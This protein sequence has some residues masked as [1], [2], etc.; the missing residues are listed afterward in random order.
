MNSGND[1]FRL[2][3]EDL[4]ADIERYT[5]AAISLKRKLLRVKDLHRRVSKDIRFNEKKLVL[6]KVDAKHA[7][8]RLYIVKQHLEK[9]DVMFQQREREFQQKMFN[10]ED[11]KE[12]IRSQTKEV[13]DR[14]SVIRE[15]CRQLQISHQ[16]SDAVCASTRLAAYAA[17]R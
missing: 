6:C 4:E 13:M 3:V 8:Y 9:V 1:L 17:L 10:L 15:S 14:I 7:H 2:Q 11:L 12:G 5:N 16:L